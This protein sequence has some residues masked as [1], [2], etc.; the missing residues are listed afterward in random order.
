MNVPSEAAIIAGRYRLVRILGQGAMGTVWQAQH[1]TLKSQVAI[2]F[3]QV[4]TAPHAQ[5][6]ARFL[7]EAQAA[8]SLR[9]P[10]VVQILDHG[11]D[12]G[13]PYI[14]M[15]LLEGETLADRLARV[16]RL[17]PI[18]AARILVHVG[19]AIGRAHE[20]GIVH[21]DLKP[22][23]VFIVRN[24]D[25][26]LA[27][28]LDFGIAK[29]TAANALAGPASAGTRTGAALGTPYYMSPEQTQGA[30]NLDFRTDIWAIGVMGFECLLGRRPFDAETLGGLLLAICTGPIPVPSQS[31]AVLAG[32]DAWFARACAREPSQRFVSAK[33]TTQEFKRLCDG[34]TPSISDSM[35]P[36]PPVAVLG[37][38]SGTLVMTD[39]GGLPGQSVEGFASTNKGGSG[40]ILAKP[41]RSTA[42]PFVV[43]GLLSLGGIVLAWSL[44]KG[45]V[46]ST[47]AAGVLAPASGV[48]L[49]T[50]VV[51]LTVSAAAPV[52]LASSSSAEPPASAERAATGSSSSKHKEMPPRIAPPPRGVTPPAANPTVNLG[53]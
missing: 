28:V 25:E 8:A 53:I 22:A 11:V 38:L 26:E 45:S 20:A 14:A 48:G 13:M 17:S 12:D 39:L 31:G 47:S 43:L 19:R 30:K 32:F 24:D 7:R 40:S 51:P 4:D 18:E 50:P 41:K 49:P 15:E 3:I 34:G 27:K 1:L 33:E 42:L 6:L 52:T 29:A 37:A 21:R 35:R 44:L 23:N 5:A 16:G 36:T 2:K 9:S 46:P 10:H